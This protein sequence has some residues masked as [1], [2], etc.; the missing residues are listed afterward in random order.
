MQDTSSQSSSSL[1]GSVGLSFGAGGVGGSLSLNGSTG[2]GTSAWVAEQSGIFAGD[3]VDITVGGNTDLVGGAIVS[4]SDDLTLD[5]GTLT[6]SDLSDHDTAESVE[7]GLSLSGGL[8]QPGTPGW[9][10]EGS[11]S[12]HDKEQET[13]AT[14]GEGEIV[15]RDTDAQE[16]L[17]DAG[18][19]E[20]VANIN[21][22]PDLAQEITKD[23]ESYIGLYASDTS[24]AAAVEA[25]GAV[26]EAIEQHF[27][28]YA[29]DN[30]LSP[31]EQTAML[32]L[33]EYYDDP[34]VL[35]QLGACVAGQQAHS[36]FDPFA[37]I[38]PRAYA[39]SVCTVSLPSGDVIAL[40]SELVV[41]C[42]QTFDVVGAFVKGT[43]SKAAGPLAGIVSY[44]AETQPA[45]GIGHD[46]TYQLPDG[47][48]L[49]VSGYS[50]D[51]SLGVTITDPDGVAVRVH[52]MESGDGYVLT[53]A[54]I[55]GQP[56]STAF[57]PAFS[58]D[59]EQLT[60][61][62]VVVSQNAHDDG[63]ADDGHNAESESA[64]P[65]NDGPPVP[66]ATPGRETRLRTR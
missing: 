52:M 35:N 32:A 31:D 22:D 37:L 60:G 20:T 25:G 55:Q 66:D 53:G 62:P 28:Q 57:L 3:A 6:V 16:A 8:N 19:T 1:G 36:G 15:I 11:A 40:S 14:I 65:S 13:R 29:A 47:T 45:G 4:E 12:G 48:T 59:L 51:L 56:V 9:S 5:T 64:R 33:A 54:S 18:V 58:A 63:G 44:F 17:E 61:K 42:Q 27:A 50:D 7:G 23:E 41:T 26:V 2:N 24:V 30:Q 34:S 43:L 39:A 46:T 10:V 21:R 38:V 49:H